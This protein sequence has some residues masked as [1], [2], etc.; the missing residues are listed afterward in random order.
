MALSQEHREKLNEAVHFL[1]DERDAACKVKCAAAEV[2]HTKCVNAHAEA[3][4]TM[5][6]VRADADKKIHEADAMPAE[7]NEQI[8]AKQAAVLKARSDAAAAMSAAEQACMDARA[9]MV[10]A[11]GSLVK[12]ENAVAALS[13]EPQDCVEC[14]YEH[15]EF[16]ADEATLDAFLKPRRIARLEADIAANKQ[17]AEDMEAQLKA[18]KE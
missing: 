8:A 16:L 15:P 17:A 1:L 6:Q 4:D 5:L 12:A 13:R 3:C 14:Q 2:E 18:L 9:A 10:A 7:T 11:K